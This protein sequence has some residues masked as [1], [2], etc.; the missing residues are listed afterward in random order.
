MYIYSKDPGLEVF[1]AAGGYDF[2]DGTISCT[3]SRLDYGGM[4]L[5]LSFEYEV[6]GDNLTLRTISSD[7]QDMMPMDGE[8]KKVRDGV[9][10]VTT[11]DEVK[12]DSESF[13]SNGLG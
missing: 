12:L 1:Y 9:V 8:Y 5:E 11:M 6:S 3:A 7:I 13:G 2:S 4:P 10:H